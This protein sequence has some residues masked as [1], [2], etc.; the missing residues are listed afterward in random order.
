MLLLSPC[1][2][3]LASRWHLTALFTRCCSQLF[4]ACINEGVCAMLAWYLCC[5]AVYGHRIAP[6]NSLGWF[7]AC[8]QL[9]HAWRC[10][11]QG[12]IKKDKDGYKDEFMLQWRHYKACLDIFNLKPS[13]E[14]KQFSDLV[15]FIAHV[16]VL[17]MRCA[18][19]DLVPI[20]T[21]TA[22]A[23]SSSTPIILTS[24]ASHSH[25]HYA[26][27]LLTTPDTCTCTFHSQNSLH[28]CCTSTP[29]P[30]PPHPLTPLS[31]TG[32]QVLP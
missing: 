21:A 24:Q 15:M 17:N 14:S 1:G 22:A 30:P 29:L 20:S 11:L 16:S 23:S 25:H 2:S 7:R 5:E 6:Q 18:S 19:A 32:Q 27:I 9:M 4:Y 10:R 13:N 28:S 12:H 3:T 31:H 8:Q 26:D